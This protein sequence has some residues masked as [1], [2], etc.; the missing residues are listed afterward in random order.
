MR[1]MIL[2]VIGVGVA[3]ALL[4]VA[5]LR[6]PAVQDFVHAAGHRST[7]EHAAEQ[8]FGDDG[9]CACCSAAPRR[10]CRTRRGPK[11]CVAV[12]AAGRFWVVDTGPGSWNRLALWQVDGRNI[13][14]VLLTHFHSDHIG[15]LGEFNLQTWGAGR[16]GPLQVFGPP[17][18]ERVVAGFN[19]AYALDPDTASPI[20]AVSCSPRTSAHGGARDCRPGRRRGTDRCAARKE[21]SPSPPSP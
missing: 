15:E 11:P 2:W 4:V 9:A 10:R 21:A 8:L 1:R 6:V 18:V 7:D 3:A 17:G 19:E 14:G 16:P 20:T 12:F 13:G 5:G